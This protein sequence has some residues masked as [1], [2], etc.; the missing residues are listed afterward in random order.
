MYKR[1][2]GT[3]AGIGAGRKA[4]GGVDAFQREFR[5]ISFDRLLPFLQ[6][7]GP[8][9]KESTVRGKV[10]DFIKAVRG[11]GLNQSP[12]IHRTAKVL[13]SVNTLSKKGKGRL[14]LGTS[15]AGA[16]LGSLAGY[17]T[18]K[19]IKKRRHTWH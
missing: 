7:Y 16:A 4:A 14:K 3:L 15:L 1:Q 9:V 19:R 6:R 13:D 8:V 5:G 11:K 10:R 18:G 2:A 12:F 17:S